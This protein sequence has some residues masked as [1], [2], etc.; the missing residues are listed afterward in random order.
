MILL[1]IVS[2]TRLPTRTAPIN[3]MTEA[4]NMAC[5]MVK[6]LELTLVAKLLAASEVSLTRPSDWDKQESKGSPDRHR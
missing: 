1:R 3:S 4:I 6:D 5:F 2:A